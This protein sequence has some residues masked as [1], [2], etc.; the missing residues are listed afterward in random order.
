MTKYIWIGINA[1]ALVLAL[2]VW[3]GYESETLR[4]V[5]LGLNAIAFALSLPAGLILIPVAFAVNYYLDINPLSTG[6]IYFNTFILLV[7]G[8]VQHTLIAT[9][10]K[11]VEATMQ[12]IG[13]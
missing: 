6:G 3:F 4:N 10:K 9:L 2:T 1:I 7:V 8:G 12:R 11:P 13:I 5:C